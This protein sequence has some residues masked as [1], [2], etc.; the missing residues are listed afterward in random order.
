MS[1]SSEDSVRIVSNDDTCMPVN[2]EEVLTRIENFASYREI[3]DHIVWSNAQTQWLPNFV[4]VIL[5]DIILDWIY[6]DIKPLDMTMSQELPEA[7]QENEVKR[8]RVWMAFSPLELP[9]R[10]HGVYPKIPL[11]CSI[12]QAQGSGIIHRCDQIAG[13]SYAVQSF[14]SELRISR[15]DECGIRSFFRIVFN[16]HRQQVDDIYRSIVSHYALPETFLDF[17]R[18]VNKNQFFSLYFENLYNQLVL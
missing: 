15:D 18:R 5:P 12:S 8:S 16:L 3:D 4:D 2:Y 13:R 11:I 7:P 6:K 17:I 9:A 14:S 1:L 10:F